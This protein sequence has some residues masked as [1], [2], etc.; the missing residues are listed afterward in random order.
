MPKTL[1]ISNTPSK[2]NEKIYTILPLIDLVDNRDKSHSKYAVIVVDD[3]I[4]ANDVKSFEKDFNYNLFTDLANYLTG[5]SIL[6]KPASINYDNT[7][8]WFLIGNFRF[9]SN[10][11]FN[12]LSKNKSVDLKTFINSRENVI[13]LRYENIQ[14]PSS[15]E[16]QEKFRL[17]K[18]DLFKKEH[19]RRVEIVTESIRSYQGYMDFIR[20]RKIFTNFVSKGI[21]N[22]E[23]LDRTIRETDAN[24]YSKNLFTKIRQKYEGTGPFPYSIQNPLA[25][26]Y[27]IIIHNR[28]SKDRLFYKNRQKIAET[29]GIFDNEKVK[30]CIIQSSQFTPIPDYDPVQRIKIK[31]DDIYNI[32]MKPELD[33]LKNSGT[34]MYETHLKSFRFIQNALQKPNSKET[35]KLRGGLKE[36][37]NKTRSIKKI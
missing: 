35:Q 25:I 7:Q 8:T 36:S 9:E 24:V 21:K 37:K 3:T 6:I 29:I 12:I 10:K 5:Y 19:Q 15:D 2:W 28:I 16:N 22:T 18:E 26:Y 17:A 4:T 32:W 27:V 23:D 11:L 20:N 33:K 30:G 34:K 14:P 31:N 13:E 1:I